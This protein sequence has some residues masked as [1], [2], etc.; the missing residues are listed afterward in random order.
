MLVTTWMVLGYVR[1]FLY[2]AGKFQKLKC[3][4][5]GRL[6]GRGVDFCGEH[7]QVFNFT[8]YTGNF[9]LIE[10]LLINSCFVCACVVFHMHPRR[11]GWEIS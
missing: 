8:T 11:G 4:R 5:R 2:L 3:F 1:T 7:K 10:V 9:L 6:S